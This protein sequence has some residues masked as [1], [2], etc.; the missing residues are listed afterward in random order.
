MKTPFGT[1]GS[2]RSFFS[3]NEVKKGGYL[4]IKSQ[5]RNLTLYKR[6]STINCINISRK[7]T[8]KCDIY[9]IK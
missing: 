5:D 9:V 1:G 6:R 8:K 3:E 7:T 4:Y 2:K